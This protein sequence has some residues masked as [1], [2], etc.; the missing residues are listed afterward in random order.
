MNKKAWIIFSMVCVV[1][2]GGLIIFSLKDRVDVSKVDTNMVLAASKESG[3]IA[4][5]V[6]GKAD[7]KVLFVEYGDFQ[8]PGCGGA[9]PTVKKVLAK[10]KDTVAFV[11]RN[12][13]LVT[14]HPNARAAAAAA[15]AA[16]LQGKYWDMHNKL[17]ENQAA[18]ESLAPNDR[19]N[20]FAEY[21]ADLGLK[22]DKF[23]ADMASDGVNQKI[24]FDQALGK[25]VKVD[26]TPTFF[27][28]GQKS[29]DIYN[30]QGG[31]DEDKLDAALTRALKDAGIT[32]PAVTQ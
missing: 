8:C 22:V 26:A 16:G 6:Y 29:P 11:F 23:K 27:L 2:L 18:W 32:V 5:H 7:S 24:S 17:F 14:K 15:E 1:L 10:Y 4:D 12:F 3:N 19:T 28:N 9:H 31:V 25:K 30:D 20:F 13:P 21:A